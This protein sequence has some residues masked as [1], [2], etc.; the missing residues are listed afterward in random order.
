MGTGHDHGP[1]DGDFSRAFALGIGLNLA[2]AGAEAAAGL[3][4]GSMALLA[5]AGHNLSDVL[6]LAIAWIGASLSHR[7]PSERFTW[8]LR[9]APILASL[10]NALL[11][12]LALGAVAWEAVLRLADPPPAPGGAMIVVA[13]IG[14]FVNLGTALLFVRGRQRDLN[15][16]GAYLHMAADAA[17]SAGVVVAGFL[18]LATSESRIDP[19]VSL[20]IA[21]IILWNGLSLMRRA[22][23]L[24]LGAVPEGIDP[25]AVRGSLA[26][27]PGVTAVHDLHIWPLGTADAVMTAHLVI[28]G[29]H[30]GNAFLDGAREEMKSRFGIGHSTIQIELDESA[31]CASCEGGPGIDNLP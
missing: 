12:I 18:I 30:P 22:L 19:V 16:E 29:A 15:I 11:L 8:G 23:M 10:G 24:S 20:L 7:P 26:A 4:F 31:D 21:A 3:W 6:G 9:G 25:A 28:A 5:D 2:F 14:I 17:V 27:L 13:G 1:A